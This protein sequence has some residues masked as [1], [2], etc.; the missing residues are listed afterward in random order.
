[1]AS[2]DVDGWLA[3]RRDEREH[4]RMRTL[5]ETK[6]DE[7]VERMMV[8]RLMAMM[9]PLRCLTMTGTLLLMACSGT[10]QETAPRTEIPAERASSNEPEIPTESTPEAQVL[11]ED[12][13]EAS[14]EFSFQTESNALY[15]TLRQLGPEPLRLR[16][17]LRVEAEPSGGELAAPLSLRAA[18]DEAPGECITLVG[19]AEFEL[20]AFTLE[21]GQCGG[22]CGGC[23]A[24]ERLRFVVK[25][26]PPAGH[27][28]RSFVSEAL[29]S[30]FGRE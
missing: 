19:G 7:I 26:C 9:S 25:T 29:A 21:E 13:T 17:T 12:P 5:R 18:C 10:S 28:A 3:K 27:R 4:L 15:V 30:G 1:M 6:P 20:A 2:A 8:V 23:S 14:V 22:G 24:A 16:S 11:P